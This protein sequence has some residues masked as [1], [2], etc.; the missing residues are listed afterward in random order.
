VQSL[1]QVP[2]LLGS[3]C[4]SVHAF[5][6]HWSPAAQVVS[7]QPSEPPSS[8]VLASTGD[9]LSPFVNV[10]VTA[11]VTV[12]QV[13]QKLVFE[14]PLLDVPP[15]LDEPS[16]SHVASASW[17]CV[18]SGPSACCVASAEEKQLDAVAPAK[19]RQQS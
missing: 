1:P 19:V 9:V 5:P 14:P 8:P 2:Q 6:Q 16:C 10:A 4:V 7:P 3:V 13:E 11:Q 15:S 18:E 12:P 17:H